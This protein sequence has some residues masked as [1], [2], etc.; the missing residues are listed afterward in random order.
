VGLFDEEL[1]SAVDRDIFVRFARH[2]EFATIPKPLVKVHRHSGTQLTDRSP[3]RVAVYETIAEKHREILQ[4]HPRV[5]SDVYYRIGLKYY[6]CGA[7]QAAR[8]ALI[9]SLSKYPFRARAWIYLFS[10]ELF[11][12]APG[13]VFKRFSQV[14][15]K[16]AP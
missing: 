1:R 14:L 16:K 15:T 6:V 10:F 7:K 3:K 11:D 13:E 2:F 4:K 8:Y 12:A 5:Y 9:R